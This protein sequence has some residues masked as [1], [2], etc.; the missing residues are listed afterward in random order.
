MK[1][2]KKEMEGG[3]HP[4]KVLAALRTSIPDE[5]FKESLVSNAA[6]TEGPREV[7]LS[8]YFTA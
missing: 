2:L 3:V 1:L 5:F 8:E 6:K 7:I 4:L